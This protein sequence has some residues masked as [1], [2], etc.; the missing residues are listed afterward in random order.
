LHPGLT[1]RFVAQLGAQGLKT[2]GDVVAAGGLP[3]GA[4]GTRR[5]AT[6][7]GI[8]SAHAALSAIS[9][10]ITVNAEL[11]NRG[12][13]SASAIAATPVAAFVSAVGTGLGTKEARALHATAVAV[14]RFI[15][16][17]A[18][19]NWT[20]RSTSATG[21]SPP[22]I[23][24]D[25]QCQDCQSATSPLAYLADLLDYTV[26]HVLLS[27]APVDVPA[28][29]QLF[30][31][32]FG[33]IPASCD[34][35]TRQLPQVRICVEALRNYLQISALPA[36]MEQ[37]YCQAAYESLLEGL[38]TS[39]EELAAART[40]TPQQRAALAARLGLA[41]S[42]SRPDQLDD[43]LI[44]P[45]ALSEAGLAALFGLAPTD[46]TA[47]PAVPQ[48]AVWRTDALQAAWLAADHPATSQPND[49]PL[50]DPDVIGPADIVNP[51]PG[52][53]PYDRWAER[54]TF[55]DTHLQTLQSL[56]GL[57]AMISNDGLTESQLIA[58]DDLRAAGQDVSAALIPL[59]LSLSSF[60]RLAQLCR[61]DSGGTPLLN[62]EL[63]DAVGILTERAKVLQFSTWRP[64]ESALYV[65]PGLFQQPASGSSPM[66]DTAPGMWLVSADQRSA[67]DALLAERIAEA[68]S[69]AA[70]LGS[71]VQGAEAAALPGL[72]N[73]LLLSANPSLTLEQSA[74]V[75][76]DRLLI[77]CSMAGAE[78]TTPV[79][80]AVETLQSI[81][82][83]L[84]AGALGASA[85]ALALVDDSTFDQEWAWMGTYAAWR[86]AIQ[87]FIYPEN[88]LLPSLRP[89]VSPVL[90][91]IFAQARG[92]VDLTPEQARQL[93][94]GYIA[95][96]RD[97]ITLQLKTSC[98][99]YT[100]GEL[101]AIQQGAPGRRL[102]YLFA[103]S[104]SQT[105]YWAAYDPAGESP[106][107]WT[108]WT[109]LPQL[110][111]V[112][113]LSGAVTYSSPDGNFIYLY[114]EV[115]QGGAAQPGFVKLD[116]H[117]TPVQAGGFN[118]IDTPMPMVFCTAADASI[119][120]ETPDGST[121]AVSSSDA[122]LPADI[123]GDGCKELIARGSS[124]V[125]IVREQNGGVVVSWRADGTIPAVPGQQSAWPIGA[126]DQW[127][128]IDLDDD[129]LEEL[130]VTNGSA[131]AVVSWAAGTLNVTQFFEG[132]VPYGGQG[133]GGT[134]QIPW[135][136]GQ[137]DQML[138]VDLAG[139]S[140]L[141]IHNGTAVGVLAEISGSLVTCTNYQGS[142]DVPGIGHW[143]FTTKDHLIAIDLDG[144]GSD[145]LLIGNGGEVAIFVV[146]F[147]GPGILWLT[148]DQKVSNI[149]GKH[150]FGTIGVPV[151]QIPQPDGS[152]AALFAL[153]GTNN[154]PMFWLG[155]AWEPDNQQQYNF[156]AQLLTA[157]S[158]AIDV[159]LE[160]PIVLRHVGFLDV[161][162]AY[163]VDGPD[164]LVAVTQA[165]PGPFSDGT[166]TLEWM[167]DPATPWLNPPGRLHPAALG[168]DLSATFDFQNVTTSVQWI[169]A[170]ID[171]D[172]R[173]EVLVFYGS[174]SLIGVIKAFGPG[175][176]VGQIAP[177]IDPAV[178]LTDIM[179]DAARAAYRQLVTTA[180]SDNAGAPAWVFSYLQEAFYLLPVFL[181]LQLQ[182]SRQDPSALD[183]FRV[184][185]D[186]ALP[187]GQRAIWPALAQAASGGSFPRPPDWLLD[188][189]D[190]HSIAAARDGTYARY[191]LLAVIEC[192]LDYADLEF[193]A[194]TAE[195]V[196][197]AR[198]FY[199]TAQRLLA[200]D[201]LGQGDGCQDLIGQL[202]ILIDDPGWTD[203]WLDLVAQASAIPDRA[204]LTTA[205]SAMRKAMNGRAALPA[206][207]AN[208][209]MALQAQ[210]A[211]QAS[212][213]I[214]GALERGRARRDA[215]ATALVA[216][217]RSEGAP[218]SFPPP[219][220]A[221]NAAPADWLTSQP[222]IRPST[223]AV[224]PGPQFAF[225]VPPNP[226]TSRLV[227]RANTALY[228]LR[229]CL[230]ISGIPRP[231][232]AD[233]TL[234]SSLATSPLG[235]QGTPPTQYPYSAL[236]ARAQQFAQMAA[237]FEAVIL[238]AMEQT[239]LEN[240]N[241]LTAGQ[242]I[243]L[244]AAK[245]Q[246][247]QA[248]DQ[249]ALDAVSVA[250]LQRDR[251]TIQAN[252]YQSWLAG[253]LNDY[254]TATIDADFVAA[255]LSWLTLQPGSAASS[256][257]QAFAATASYERRTQEWQLQL[258]LAQQD[259]AIGT[260]QIA[261][262]AAGQTVA[263]DSVTEASLEAQDATALYDFLRT[264]QLTAE[265]WAQMTSVLAGVYR[266]FL[267]E[268]TVLAQVAAQEL[269][270]ERQELV[271]PF[272][273]GDYW[274]TPLTGS[275]PPTTA[276]GST[277]TGPPS[278]LTGSARL[279]NDIFQ[280]DQYAFDT[281]TR[282][283]QISKTIS[284]ATLDPFALQQFR[285]SGAL[286]FAT[287]AELF[288]RDFPGHYLRTIRRVTTSLIAL[289]PPDQGIKATLSSSGL[290]RV[291]IDPR[292]T[293]SVMCRPPESVA[294]SAP[295]GATGLFQLDVQPE[296]LLPFEGTGVDTSWQLIMPKAS[297]WFDYN[298]IADVL[299]TIDY[300]ALAS[301]DYARIVKARLG[302]DLSSDN[303]F[304]LQYDFPD[305]WYA[306]NNPATTPTPMVITIDLAI[307]DFPAT[308]TNLTI[309][310]VVMA[311]VLADGAA[312]AVQPTVSVALAGGPKLTAI[313]DQDIISTR[314]P[315]GAP[316]LALGG[317]AP[318]GAWQLFFDDPQ[319]SAAV[320]AALASG[321]LGD[322]MLVV[323][324]DAQT[325]AWPG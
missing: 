319:T 73:A 181:A 297:N 185:Y 190:P 259:A 292:G 60:E 167:S 52:N 243:K 281:N 74:D 280:L 26:R 122:F 169:P 137:N 105:A 217:A 117:A 164:P 29:E 92:S 214:A 58:L 220:P 232:G 208:A 44:D 192:L 227:L 61:L 86:A 239:D 282:K 78:L 212:G 233:A 141:V 318:T 286:A 287:P 55:V 298:T 171:G 204:S 254:E 11:V 255:Q 207:I 96:L 24:A 180:V 166:I 266:F 307:S 119:Q 325:G 101:Q 182:G 253:G 289:I 271:P 202:R 295:A 109:A 288:D 35:V 75:L 90:S 249:Q 115:D 37:A 112:R 27:G 77:D 121:W 228:R 304:S 293:Q 184:V 150:P 157:S 88:F 311:F 8:V 197:Q 231:A 83:A 320:S 177:V 201:V 85:P 135:T 113:Q 71:A 153:I 175:V 142:W 146:D 215:W 256:V 160:T 206:R 3:D 264:K 151:G 124:S 156:S 299:V 125:A 145:V 314:R 31:Q 178:Q 41:L 13:T 1:R 53:P 59:G 213:D 17:R 229:S 70:S 322:I 258:A 84:W 81:V 278:G 235:G 163:D 49:P 34:S 277:T 6:A 260:A 154:Q 66:P 198:L 188:P 147:F 305:Q 106:G 79:T 303:A 301:D 283:L 276:G 196:S 2:V 42:P 144:T 103:V 211:Q 300:T 128:A 102:T 269:A 309:A 199:L 97:V 310:Q 40:M 130:V 179:S 315:G 186:Y 104:A 123:D 140:R 270:F 291:V 67:W 274:G 159:I 68:A 210:T 174:G 7:A 46:G 22:P 173:E 302:A 107:T 72:R 223:P 219:A 33:S 131:L 4:N 236:I 321:Q 230:N 65:G 245:F 248:Q 262:A 251:A 63:A 149:P 64:Q 191:T 240:Q 108:L 261:V 162:M 161:M 313:A 118:P 21:A 189:L 158:A 170:D 268:A 91:D 39:Y 225:C 306:L 76:E 139:A 216:R 56:N 87:V 51:T 89:G 247:A 284:L 143:D 194:A 23:S 132:S 50:I 209:R 98:T 136:L 93:A 15:L 114:A 5:D 134:A 308:L 32:K 54:R 224:T 126:A 20:A 237:Q 25:C 38:G 273:Q 285:Q 176:D 129:G 193:A 290:S 110:G 265:V 263:D 317:Q 238:T 95:Y 272:I 165:G 246:V 187:E 252:T 221:K 12:F 18:V 296:L 203:V 36:A 234:G 218:A 45:P 30:G 226:T 222:A 28:L 275:S 16:N 99:A 43:L 172:G 111:R 94:A 127:L 200:S 148:Y 133:T 62:S 9:A 120:A 294:L 168:W 155:L 195:S 10:D 14:H 183:W 100:G 324:Y 69:A 244:S 138:R 82:T 312:L 250:Q 152:E 241:L 257:A 116:L 323:T 47:A 205:V 316:W 242:N 19:A 80:Q 279:L 48:F 57:A 267:T